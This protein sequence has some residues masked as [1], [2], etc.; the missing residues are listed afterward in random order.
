MAVNR[1]RTRS[2]EVNELLIQSLLM[3][4]HSPSRSLQMI[5]G[6]VVL[7]PCRIYLRKEVSLC[8]RVTNSSSIRISLCQYFG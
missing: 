8:L 4:G 6:F 5:V 3:I 1:S 2:K 7:G